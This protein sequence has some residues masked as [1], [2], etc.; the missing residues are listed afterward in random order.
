MESGSRSSDRIL[1]R[2]HRLRN[3][4]NRGEEEK[5][6]KEKLLPLLKF[7]LYFVYSSLKEFLE[8]M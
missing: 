8:K 4:M 6:K 3:G 2:E 7:Y 5:K 1:N